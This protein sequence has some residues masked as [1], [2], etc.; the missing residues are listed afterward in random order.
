[1]NAEE[2]NAIKLKWQKHNRDNGLS[3]NEVSELVNELTAKSNED[4]PCKWSYEE[5]YGYFETE[6]GEAYSLIDG[7]LEENKHLYC[8]FCGGKIAAFGKEGKG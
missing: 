4:A 2:I 1:M 5:D 8:P 6:C 3:W 7:T